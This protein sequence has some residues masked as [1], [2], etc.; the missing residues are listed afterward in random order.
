MLGAVILCFA[1]AAPSLAQTGGFSS[2]YS[3]SWFDGVQDRTHDELNPVTPVVI[4]Y[5]VGQMDPDAPDQSIA[6]QTSLVTENGRAVTVS[7]S[8][9]SSVSAVAT[10]P[11]L[12]DAATGEY[13]IGNYSTLTTYNSQYGQT[14]TTSAVSVGLSISCY[15]LFSVNAAIHTAIMHRIIPCITACGAQSDTLTFSYNPALGVP[16]TVV[17]AE[18]YT[19]VG[20]LKICSHITAPPERVPDGTCR[21]LNL[22]IDI[23]ITPVQPLPNLVELGNLGGWL[24]GGG[25]TGP[26]NGHGVVVLID[27]VEQPD[28]SC[29]SPIIIDVTG[30]GFKLTDA[31]NGVNFDLDNDDVPERISWTAADSGNAFLVL[32]RNHNGRVDGGA[33]LFGNFTSQPPSDTPNGFLALAEY[34]KPANGGNGDGIIDS[35]DGVFSRLRLWQD[36]NHNGISE[37]DE[38]S[39]LPGLGV[40]AVALNYKESKKR[41]GYGNVFRYR[42]KVYGTDHHNLGRW[43]FDVFFKRAQ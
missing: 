4:G 24:G 18:P 36:R 21:C 25:G 41:D 35:R 5:S 38:L 11:I 33:E 40:E 39:T 28:L 1:M 27:G 2:V 23:N 30:E 13:E 9:Y 10:M 34:D 17:V 22:V 32:D 29:Y 7:N 26:C 3:D 8:G 43:A 42:A 31:A 12:Y 15:V 20:F 37:P 19:K 14:V 16:T 6:V